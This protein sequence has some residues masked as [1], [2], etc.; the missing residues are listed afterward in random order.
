MSGKEKEA[1]LLGYSGHGYVVAEAAI[2]S[3]I[4]LIG[5]AESTE[6]VQNPYGLV[7][8][9]DETKEE[10][11]WNICKNY[12]LGVGANS[13]RERIASRVIAHGG[14]LLSIIHPNA[15][16]SA[17]VVIGSGTFVAR[18]VSVNPLVSI[19][20]NVILNTSCSIDHE[21]QIE[22]NV[23]IAPGAVLAGNVKVKGG[24]F[25]GANSVIKEGV[26]IGE[27]AVVGAGSVV[28][29]DVEAESVVVGNPAKRYVNM[30]KERVLIIA[31]AGVNHNGDIE[32]AK[33]LIDAA[34]VAGVDLVKFQTFKAD[35]LVS[36][37]AKQAAYQ[38]KNIGS[39]GDSQYQML[40]QLELSEETHSALKL[41][42]QSKSVQFF[43]TAFDVKGLDYL[44][45]LGFT[46]FKV[47]SGEIT[48]YPYLRKLAEFGKPVILST[49]MADLQEIAVALDILLRG[50]KKK[51]LRYCNAT[52]SI[53]RPWK[54]STSRPCKPLVG[55]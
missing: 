26:F 15:S 4:E 5:Y 17:N 43:S 40:K 1:I 27:R 20:Q 30:H 47:P 37:A 7:F 36:K 21:C 44:N 54:M 12:V 2:L 52:P 45:G 19:G 42:A 48:N 16:V 13:I 6:L 3:G 23:H 41:H 49:G 34:A 11:N 28:I 10:F 46:Q 51:T 32:R 8:L 24:A 14:Q 31:E 33:Q 18:L 39:E 29:R 25:I 9:G 22:S 38:N 55:N 50:V 35:D 53:L